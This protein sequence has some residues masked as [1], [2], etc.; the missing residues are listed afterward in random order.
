MAVAAPAEAMTGGAAVVR[1]LASHGV[2]LVFGIPGTHTL[3]IHRHLTACGIRHVTPR[4]EQGGGYAADGYARVSAR[5]GV[6]LA[7]SGPGVINT[8]TAVATAYADSVPLL[9]VSPGM[10]TGVA[11]RDMGFLHEGKDQSAAMDAVASWSR[12]AG[13]PAEAA[14]AIAA[15]FEH[16]VAGRPRPVHVEVPVDVL[17][18]RGDVR[19]PQPQ[20]PPARALD[21]EALARAADVLAR[22]ERPA[23]VLGGGARGAAAVATELAERLGAP[24]VT[25]VNGKGV[26]SER[27][28][29]SL[30]AQIRLSATQR[31]LAERD[32]VLAVGTELGESDLWGAMPRLGGR[33]VRVDVDPG[34][35]NKNAAAAVAVAGDARRVLEALLAAL[36]ARAGAGGEDLGRA[37]AAMRAEALADGA[38]WLRLVEALDATLGRDGVLA[39]DSTMSAY[40]GAVHFLPMDTDRRFIYPTGYAT[41]GY[42]LPAAIGAKLAAPQRPVI[43]LAGDGGLLFTVAELVTA[44][45]LGIPLPVVVPNNR[46]Y[47]EIR[48]QMR[49]D[50]ID[51]IGVDLRVPD[52]PRLGEACGGAGLRVEDPDALAPAIREA[53]ERPGPTVIEV[54]VASP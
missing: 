33:L 23:L 18:Q 45:E 52:L 10:P 49:A 35:L 28:P 30:G 24:V 25:T 5:P 4:H 3:P 15:A 42:A 14:E 53:L 8:A 41:L 13:S 20:V 34:Q 1:A 47:G 38:P 9:V 50:G 22:A 11:G 7:T 44:A 27:H 26:V 6:V 39:G 12:R 43:A 46:G 29:L 31:W 32:A 51:P 2:E 40:Y 54:P 48:A 21:E 19:L 36:P 17:E 16:F 37:R